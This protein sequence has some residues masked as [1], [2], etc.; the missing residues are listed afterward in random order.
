MTAGLDPVAEYK[1]LAG[2]AEAAGRAARAHIE[3]AAIA[4]R[5]MLHAE[6]G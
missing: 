6:A 5:R 4:L 1:I 3:R 2:N